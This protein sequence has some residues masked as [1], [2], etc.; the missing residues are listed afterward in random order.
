ME[1]WLDKKFEDLKKTENKDLNKKNLKAKRIKAN[2]EKNKKDFE[3]FINKFKDLFNKLNMVKEE[4]FD[5]YFE[6]KS[7]DD[8]PE[9]DEYYFS[10]ENSTQ[11]PTF[12]RRFCISVSDEDNQ[13]L[14][15]LFR[16]KRNDREKPWKFHDEQEFLCDIFKLDEERA[17]ELIDWFAWKI[18]TQ[19]GLR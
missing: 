4:G 5:Y 11:H 3:T 19:R 7:M 8:M 13:M 10:G 2:F 16:G 12:L 1:H 18:Y 14:I 9:Y 17:Y 15:K 6:F